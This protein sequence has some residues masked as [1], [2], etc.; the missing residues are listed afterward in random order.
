MKQT[1][2]FLLVNIINFL[3]RIREGFYHPQFKLIFTI[4]ITVDRRWELIKKY[5]GESSVPNLQA[6]QDRFQYRDFPHFIQTWMW[7]NQFLRE[8]EDF[9]LGEREDLLSAYPAAAGLI[10]TLT[11]L[12]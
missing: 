4:D 5:G 11:R 7:K 1:I 10:R 12:S 8:Y 3:N 2:C 9:T 6:L